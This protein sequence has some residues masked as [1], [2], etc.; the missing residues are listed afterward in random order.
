MKLAETIVMMV[1]PDY[2]ERFKAEYAQLK[3]RIEGLGSM[4]EKYKNE[5]L[6]FKPTCSCDLLEYQL[7]NMKEYMFAL[8]ERARVEDVDLSEFDR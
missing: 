6:S 8:K 5:E 3:I 7:K 1:S 2:K 4:V